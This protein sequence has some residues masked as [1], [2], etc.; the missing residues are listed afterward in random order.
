MWVKNKWENETRP[1]T[2]TPKAQNLKPKNPHV[3][4]KNAQTKTTEN[5]KTAISQKTAT[6]LDRHNYENTLWISDHLNN[7][8]TWDE[9]Q[10]HV[11]RKTNI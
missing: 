7:L 4:P 9:G 10:I 2:Q 5:F 8:D 3:C 6:A 1:N 11:A